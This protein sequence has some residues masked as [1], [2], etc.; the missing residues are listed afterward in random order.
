LQLGPREDSNQC[1]W[2]LAHRDREAEM[3]RPNS[4]N[5][6]GEPVRKVQGTRAVLTRGD[7][8]VGVS[9][10]GLNG[11]ELRR[12]RW[13]STTAAVFRHDGSPAVDRR[14]GNS[15]RRVRRFD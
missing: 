14:W 10:R 7:V 13:S 5:G 1:N 2:V 4:S 6:E 3:C 11:G 8:Q 9:R 12:R 15:S